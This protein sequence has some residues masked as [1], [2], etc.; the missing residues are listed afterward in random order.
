MEKNLPNKVF[1]DELASDYDNMI[2]FEKTVENKKKLLKN[3][4]T[5]K[6]KSAADVGCGSGV[7][8][9]ALASLGLNVTAFDPSVEMLKVAEANAKR[10]NVKVGFH[11][12]SAD[13]IP[14]EFNNNFDL[15]A[16]LGNT[17]ANITKEK[18]LT[19]LQRCYEILRPKG[20]L[21]IQVLNYH[22]IL[23]EKQRIVNI[24]EGEKGYF[25]RFYDFTG[26]ELVFNVLSFAKSNL[27]DN[28]LISTKLYAHLVKDFAAGLKMTGFSKFQFYSDLK[29]TSF[30]EKQSKDLFIQAFK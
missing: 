26:D 9:I 1:Y 20:Q 15:V 14:T 18:F 19:S 28:K 13:N 5:S 21:L 17:F 12:Y 23:L 6:M 22:K 3:F 11:N 4:L 27:S 2:S 24:T 30:D 7:D 8:S 10:L 29:L 25:I 16:S